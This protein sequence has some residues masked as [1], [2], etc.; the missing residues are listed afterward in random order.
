M[1]GKPVTGASFYNCLQYCLEYKNCFGDLKKLTRQ[2]IDEARLN[3]RVEKPVFHFTLRAAPGDI[4][5]K[6]QFMEIGHLCAKEFGWRIISMSLF[7]IKT[8]KNHTFIL[9]P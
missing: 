6:E 8:Q 3:R 4:V 5:T 2:F 1:I 9:L 7:C